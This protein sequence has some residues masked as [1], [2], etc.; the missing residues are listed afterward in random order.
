[1]VAAFSTKRTVERS[2]VWWWRI[3]AIAARAEERLMTKHFPEAYPAYR[4]RVK[5]LVPFVL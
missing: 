4:R 5:A 2:G 1:V 3:L